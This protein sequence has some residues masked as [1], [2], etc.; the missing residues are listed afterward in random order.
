MYLIGL[1][2]YVLYSNNV[3]NFHHQNGIIEVP[4]HFSL[5]EIYCFKSISVAYVLGSA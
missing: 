1:F 2:V 4:Y 5:V 3:V